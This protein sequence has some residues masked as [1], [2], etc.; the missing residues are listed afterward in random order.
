[1]KR[2]A[3][4][5]GVGLWVL[6]MTVV[7]AQ[8]APAQEP[9]RQGGAAGAQG[10]RQGGRGQAPP[11]NLQVLPRTT[12]PQEIGPIMQQFTASLGVTCQYCHVTAADAAAPGGRGGRDGGAARQGGDGAARQGGDG[13][14]AAGAAQADGRGGRAGG[15]GAPAGMN[16]FASDA[17]IPKRT[18]RTMMLMVRDIN[19]KLNA[20][21]GKPAA[22][23]TQVTCNTCHRGAA[24][25]MAALPPPPAR[26]GGAPAGGQGG[27]GGQAPAAPPA[28][29]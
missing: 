23:V 26:G 25:P 2:L 20:E 28:Q 14:R 10:G 13:G 19:A 24:I 16:D 3:V 22:D 8:Q 27:Q 4:L 11:T 15:R 5:F 1:M 6:T 17:K 21:L 9:G 7:S 18:A 29:Q 12:T